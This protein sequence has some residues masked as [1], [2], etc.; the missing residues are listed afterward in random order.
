MKKAK[1]VIGLFLIVLSTLSCGND[2]NDVVP[3]VAEICY[4][5][6]VS[7]K[8]CGCDCPQ[9]FAGKNCQTVVT[10]SEVT[11]TKI[12]V[13]AFD[14]INSNGVN[15]DL[16]SNPDIYIKINK[17]NTVLYSQ[18]T[19]YPNAVSGL[20][21]NYSFEISPLLK[22]TEVT[23]PLIV[24]LWDYDINDTPSSS[25]DYMG[26]AAFFPFNFTG[27]PTSIV[28]TDTDTATKFEIFLSY[29]W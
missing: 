21:T 22:T 14:N 29:K 8:D 15:H 16:L 24:S 20:N 12:V 5:S 11:I 10:P 13:K 17:G 7:N 27:F 6:G 9:G 25:D 18:S 26:A 19:F 2:K 4:N 28:V 23:A 1:L 3:C